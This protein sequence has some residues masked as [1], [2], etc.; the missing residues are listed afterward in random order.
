MFLLCFGT[1]TVTVDNGSMEFDAT[2]DS[3]I[4]DCQ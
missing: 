4:S 3:M 2:L 1:L